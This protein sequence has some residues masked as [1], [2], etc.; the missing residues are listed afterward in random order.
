[1]RGSKINRRGNSYWFRY[2]LPPG[3]D[4]KRLQK[5]ETVRGSYKD[6]ERRQREILTQ[7]DQGKF[8]WVPIKI[9]LGKF[10][11]QYLE[12]IKGANPHTLSTYVAA[13]RLFKAY[14]GDNIILTDI[15]TLML[16]N[17]VNELADKKE[18]S[19]V[20]LY[21]QKLNVAMEY[22][23]KPTIRY[24]INNPCVDV[25]LNKPGYK[26]RHLWDENQSKQFIQNWPLFRKMRY[27]A[28]FVLLLDTGARIGEILALRWSDVDLEKR[29]VYIVKTALRRGNDGSPK[30]RRSI[31]K[32]FFNEGTK[33]MLLEHRAKQD[34][35]KSLYDG[36]YNPDKF[37]FCSCHGKQVSHPGA[38]YS[39]RRY[40]N[41]MKLPYITIHGL[42]HTIASML[43]D[44]GHTAVSVGE[45]LG[46]TP[47]TIMRSYAHRLPGM[48]A[49]IVKT[50][51]S[52][53]D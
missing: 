33:K 41:I 7:I 43:L 24:L 34:K 3:P 19:T 10:V 12:N 40:C 53:W 22:A 5:T 2:D 45:R 48:Q 4:G 23:C 15:T 8:S 25:I 37:V 27:I 6:A 38:F 21:F 46:D 29:E 35:E 32:V 26:E 50:I 42:R 20:R 14:F 51:G 39:F 30:S 49:E 17:A 11:D 28:L 36:E 44:K 31:R 47:E 13:L 18:K 1:V 52:L 9:T 16:Q